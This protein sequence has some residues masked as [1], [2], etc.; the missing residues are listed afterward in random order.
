MPCLSVSICLILQAIVFV[1]CKG[2]GICDVRNWCFAASARHFPGP[3][4]PLLSKGAGSLSRKRSALGRRNPSHICQPRF[5]NTSSWWPF[6]AGTV[7]AGGHH[8]PLQKQSPAGRPVHILVSATLKDQ[9]WWKSRVYLAALN[10]ERKTGKRKRHP[11]AGQRLIRV[12]WAQNRASKYS[13]DA[14]QSQ[15][16]G[17]CTSL[18]P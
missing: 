4:S 18:H 2:K 14:R 5:E 16:C 3:W 7:H 6:A 1:E 8:R 9:H 12:P 15:T 11:Q 17:M 13:I 10:M